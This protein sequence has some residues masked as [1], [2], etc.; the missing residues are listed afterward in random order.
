M[1]PFGC[2]AARVSLMAPVLGFAP[3]PEHFPQ[4]A[5]SFWHNSCS[6]GLATGNCASNRIEAEQGARQKMAYRDEEALRAELRGLTEKTRK[7]RQ[8]L[9]DMISNGN[10]RDLTR[11]LGLPSS[12]KAPADGE[13]AIAHDR[14]RQPRTGKKR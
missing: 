10:S 5:P 6:V 3:Q 4:L 8:E 14:R 9:R 13:T 7:I 11:G 2:R 1:P 12:L